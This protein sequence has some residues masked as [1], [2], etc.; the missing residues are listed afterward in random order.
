MKTQ[1]KRWAKASRLLAV[2]AVTLLFALTMTPTVHAGEYIEGEPDAV[3]DE[4][5]VV[6]DDLFIGGED[7]L[8]AGV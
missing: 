2:F 6:E 1:T 3:L 8:V 5:E 7:V 4:G